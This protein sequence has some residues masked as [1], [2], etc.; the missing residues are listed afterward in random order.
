MV[1]GAPIPAI[2]GGSGGI[3]GECAVAYAL[4]VRTVCS[5]NSLMQWR[6]RMDP[7]KEWTGGSIHGHEL[8]VSLQAVVVAAGVT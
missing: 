8:R 1:G 3:R 5:L 4:S 7:C 6:E 2:S